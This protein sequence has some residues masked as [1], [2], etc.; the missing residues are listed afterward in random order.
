M[1][2]FN[3]CQNPFTSMYVKI[4]IMNTKLTIC[5]SNIS[6]SNLVGH[7]NLRELRSKYI[8][9][10]KK[11][12]FGNYLHNLVSGISF[13]TQI[14]FHNCS[15][16]YVKWKEKSTNISDTNRKEL[17]KHFYE[18]RKENSSELAIFT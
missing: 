13:L 17:Q 16:Q 2:Y 6:Y 14:C 18:N 7:K 4:F 11:I 12:L 15:S 5:R 3:D 8:G 10:S 1:N 9:K